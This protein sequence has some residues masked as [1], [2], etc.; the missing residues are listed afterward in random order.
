MIII[1]ILSSGF[2]NPCNISFASKSV[3]NSM[4]DLLSRSFSP[5]R[6]NGDFHDVELTGSGGGAGA[7]LDKFFEDAESI[8]DELKELGSLQRRLQSCHEHIKTLQNARAVKDLR[9][10]MEWDVE[11]ALK[12][13]NAVKKRLEALERAD[14]ANPNLPGCGAGS[15]LDQTR[16]S[17][18]DGL[19]KTL[20]DNMEGFNKLR[21][22]LSSEYEETVQKPRYFAV[23]VE[24]PEEMTVD[25][26]STGEIETFL[27]KAIQEQRR[28]EKDMER[29]RKKSLRKL[30]L[31]SIFLI[32]LVVLI[33]LSVVKP[34]IY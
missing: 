9:A 14:A 17:V 4:N 2:K 23:T 33:T 1:I 21:E 29:N 26:I 8:K 19:R 32:L 13:A 15:S 12:K 34:W 18:V 3:L 11:E 22:K 7:N 30:L 5:S 10:W 16:T 24:N 28:S 31:A 25:L 6:D 20:K 27:R